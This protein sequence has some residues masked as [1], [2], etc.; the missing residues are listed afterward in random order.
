MTCQSIKIP[1]QRTIHGFFFRD[2]RKPSFII[3]NPWLN[4]F[5]RNFASRSGKCKFKKKKLR[6]SNMAGWKIHHWLVWST[7][8]PIGMRDFQPTLY[9]ANNIALKDLDSAIHHFLE[10]VQTGRPLWAFAQSTHDRAKSNDVHLD[11]WNFHRIQKFH[12]KLPLRRFFQTALHRIP[13][14]NG[15]ETFP[16]YVWKKC[17]KP[18]NWIFCPQWNAKKK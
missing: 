2:Y 14:L 15:G 13:R 5:V 7:W 4:R 9:Q 3:H 1:V 6:E 11:F 18:S 8:G 17:A 12:C 10:Q 16:R